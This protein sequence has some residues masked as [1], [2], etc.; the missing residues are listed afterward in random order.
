MNPHHIR[1]ILIEEGQI[2]DRIESLVQEMT[3]ELKDRDLVMIGILR[4]SF[5]FIADLVRE[6][7]RNHVHPRLDFLTLES[8]YGGTAS[9]GTVNVAKDFSTRVDG[10]HVLVIDDI[11]DSGRTL[12]KAHDH[13]MGKKA[14]TV[15]TCVLLDKPSRRAVPFEANYRGFEIPDEFVV[16]YGLDYDGYYRELPYIAKVSMLDGCPDQE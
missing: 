4:G 13:I 16:G 15:R 1:D 5:M 10:C 9:S 14:D 11:L 6:L 7:F 2:K 12:A 3:P 8:Y